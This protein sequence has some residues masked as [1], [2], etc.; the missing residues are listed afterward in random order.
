MAKYIAWIDESV[1]DS[2]I[3]DYIAGSNCL[4]LI[5]PEGDFSQEEV[6]LAIKNGFKTNKPGRGP[7]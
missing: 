4:I 5:G 1:E 6:R 7:F 3:D 2:L